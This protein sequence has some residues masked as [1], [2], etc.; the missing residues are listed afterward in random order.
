MVDAC[1]NYI[2]LEGAFYYKYKESFA[3][4]LNLLSKNQI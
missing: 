3:E 4:G 1:C 2:G